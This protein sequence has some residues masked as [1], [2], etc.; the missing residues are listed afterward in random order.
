MDL[1]EA[2]AVLLDPTSYANE[3][4]F[5]E[6]T[7]LLRRESPVH[8]VEAAPEPEGPAYFPF[9]A[10]TRHGDLLAVE[11][12]H[13][14]FAN[15]PR[16]LLQA[17][18]L[19]EW[20]QANGSLL[21]TLIHMDDPE[22]RAY[23]TIAADWFHPRS[24]RLLEERA[25]ELARRFVDQMASLGGACDFVRDIAGAYPLYMILSLLGLPESDFSRMRQLTQELFGGADDELRRVE[26]P[27]DVVYE[28]LAYFK[29]L[30]LSR[31]DHP[32]G[33]L[34]SVIANARI[35]G[36]YLPEVD[37]ASYYVIIATAGH[38]TTTSTMAGGLLA[39][40]EHPEQL[41]RLQADPDLVPTAVEEMIRWVTPVKE[42]MRTAVEDSVVAGTE[43]RAGEALYLAY[44]S[45]NRDESVFDQPFSFDVA[46]SPNRHLAFGFGAHY[47]LG[48]ALARMELKAFY[49]E[50][51]PRLISIEQSG[52]APH[53]ATLFVGGLKHLPIRYELR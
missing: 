20:V 10:I 49:R 31:R 40:L 3:A 17:R 51:I 12:D 29:A 6:A 53:A 38:D 34:A 18:A 36:A 35:E 14:R 13:H 33:D 37:I 39:L 22:H 23:R 1:S 27:N 21:R 43:I 8:W 42:F 47:C 24:L 16:P 15:A 30:T 7:T 26:N 4:R 46:R 19:D 52:P 28:F 48:A 25:T 5:H 50:L 41:A 2:G 45:A 9:W 11:R 32:T 44:L